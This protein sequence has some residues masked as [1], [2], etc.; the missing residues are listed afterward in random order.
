MT[1]LSQMKEIKL[2]DIGTWLMGWLVITVSLLN[3]VASYAQWD[4]AD[5]FNY[6]TLLVA[7]I[8]HVR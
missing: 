3:F 1:A 2:K 6:Y 7:V 5:F 8:L 4:S